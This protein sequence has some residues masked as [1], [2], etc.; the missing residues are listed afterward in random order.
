MKTFRAI[1]VVLAVGFILPL[2]STAQDRET[3]SALTVFQDSTE[4]NTLHIPNSASLRLG[5]NWGLPMS[6][7]SDAMAARTMHYA[8]GGNSSLV[9]GS[10]GPAPVKVLLMSFLAHPCLGCTIQQIVARAIFEYHSNKGV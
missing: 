7:V 9:G 4:Y 6:R 5:W 1:L 2:H 10:A 3:G 8:F